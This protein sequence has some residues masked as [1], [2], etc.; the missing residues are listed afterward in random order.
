VKIYRAITG[1][2]TLCLA[3]ALL[4]GCSSSP[5]ATFYT[6]NVAA[7]NETPAA[8]LGSVAIGPITLPDLLDRPQLVVRTS[9]NRVDI[10]E[11]HRWAESLKSEI[12]RTIA[13]DLGVLLKPARVS[14]DPQNAGLDADYRVLLD[15]Q[16]FE[17]T[18]GAG[19]GLEALWSVRRSDGVVSKSGRTVV[20]EP[21]SAAGY[22][23][24]VAA[25]SRAL[26]AVSRELAQALREVARAAQSQ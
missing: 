20:S 8:A 2:T 7:I 9:A 21:V 3:V 26:A 14:S 16:R 15:I 1:M 13:A 4:A 6:L 19:V 17:M 5:K 12:P 18:A 22:D 25:Q 23:A 24:L 10:L 11:T